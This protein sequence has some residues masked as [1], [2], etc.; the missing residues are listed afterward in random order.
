MGFGGC[1]SHPPNQLPN[2]CERSDEMDR[3]CF[4]RV[5]GSAEERFWLRVDRDGPVAP[6]DP[7]LGQCWLWLG[8]INESGIPL[9]SP[10]NSR[11]KASR[12]WIYGHAVSPV[13]K[14]SFVKA[15]CGTYGCVN[16]EH[17]IVLSRSEEMRS[18]GKP[19]PPRL[20]RNKIHEMEQSG[21]CGECA[22]R[23]KPARRKCQNGHRYS[24]AETTPGTHRICATCK[25]DQ[26]KKMCSVDG[27]ENGHRYLG[28]C[29]LH[30]RR[31][32]DSGTTDEP[33]PLTEAE[34]FWA[35]V[36]CTGDHWLWVGGG[37]ASAGSFREKG[38]RRAISPRRWA[39]V[40]ANGPI[41][42]G[43][44]TQLTCG[45]DQCVRPEH[46]VLMTWAE[47]GAARSASR[48]LCSSGH[49]W[50]AENTR[51]TPA[52]VRICRSCHRERVKLRKIAGTAGVEYVKILRGDPCCYCGAPMEH[53]DHIIPVTKN[54]ER[55]WSN[56][57]AACRLCNQSK[58]TQDLLSFLLKRVAA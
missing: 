43:R 47:V 33:I 18:R 35:K 6:A 49:E 29:D 12:M 48:P 52:G 8:K 54:G 55:H 46:V 58:G 26:V 30:G 38:G 13:P 42:R 21:R 2:L 11:N 57:T 53:I 37:L 9:F 40:A 28:F 25:A 20:C 22:A 17:L 56:L 31:F 3:S 24:E 34:R 16:P 1:W 5:Y 41:P 4:K 23:P 50:T 10:Q 44:Q 51:I 39:W 45:V 32:K 27:C 14:G 7:T 15:I 19:K 36:D